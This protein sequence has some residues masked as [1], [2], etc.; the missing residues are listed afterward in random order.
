M[1]VVYF[2]SYLILYFYSDFATVTAFT[3]QK[4]QTVS[5]LKTISQAVI[6]SK[7]WSVLTALTSC[8]LWRRHN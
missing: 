3:V 7:C 2:I 8:W 4:P 1:F 5:P 6:L